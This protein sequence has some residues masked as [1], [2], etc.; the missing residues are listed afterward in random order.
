MVFRDSSIV[1]REYFGCLDK[2]M[3]RNT[4]SCFK[5]ST[6]NE[7]FLETGYNRGKPYFRS[8]VKIG[9]RKEVLNPK[10]AVTTGHSSCNS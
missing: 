4:P 2:K 10:P 1:E 5:V 9:G 7:Q 3:V 6:P 8:L